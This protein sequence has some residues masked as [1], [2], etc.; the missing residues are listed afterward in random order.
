MM[1]SVNNFSYDP[2]ISLSYM[3]LWFIPM[4]FWCFIFT[5]L[6]SFLPFSNKWWWITI[7]SIGFIWCYASKL[8]IPR[9]MGFPAFFK[10]YIWFFIGY[11]LLHY[12]EQLYRFIDKY[13]QLLIPLLLL[14]FITGSYCKC[15]YDIGRASG[16]VS[17][18]TNLSI[19][20]LI[21]YLIN[22]LIN[23]SHTDW[24]KSPVLAQLNK[25]S[26]GIFVFHYWIQPFMV[27]TTAKRL[28]GLEA[29]ADKHYILFPFLF[30]VSSFFVSLVITHYTLKT[31][32][33]RFL[34]G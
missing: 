7:V 24:V 20:I 29:L 22:L 12:R 4:L 3:H 26:Y 16:I 15:V 25:Y 6:Q 14:G 18:M 17:F 27:S 30:F 10:W 31:R 33:G 1:L 23:K 5:R 34:I 9:V 32:I 8:A 19:V 21:W 13:C 2:Y 28:F 11:N